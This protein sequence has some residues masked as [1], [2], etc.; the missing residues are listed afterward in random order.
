MNVRCGFYCP[1]AAASCRQDVLATLDPAHLPCFTGE[2]GRLK[3][4]ACSKREGRLRA[5]QTK[6]DEV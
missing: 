1:V 5:H 4:R 2:L 3:T 6:G